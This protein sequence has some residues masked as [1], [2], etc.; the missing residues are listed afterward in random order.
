MNKKL[1]YEDIQKCINDKIAGNGCKLDLTKEEF[2]EEK[3]KQNKTGANVIL[4]ILCK[5]GK[6]FYASYHS[7]SSLNKKQCNKCGIE[8]RARKNE[9]K[10][11]E[12]QNYI[13]GINGNG[14]TLNISEDEFEKY[15]EQQNKSNVNVKIPIMCAC[16]NIFK[17]SF[18]TFVGMNQK[19]CFTC[20]VKIRGKNKETNLEEI[21]SYINGEYGNGCKCYVSL[22]EFE[23]L[24]MEQNKSNV[25]VKIPITC[26]CGDVFEMN[27]SY[28]ISMKQKQCKKC[29]NESRVKKLSISDYDDEINKLKQKDC[30]VLGIN[31]K[32][33]RTLIFIEDKE[34]YK[35]KA[36]VKVIRKF[37]KNG[38]LG[39]DKFN[40]GNPYTVNNIK[41]WLTYNEPKYELLSNTYKDANSKLLWKCS[42]GHKFYAALHKFKDQGRRCP[43]CNASKGEQKVGEWLV[44]NN[45]KIFPQFIFTDLLSDLGNPL[46]FDFGVLDIQNNIHLLIEYDGGQHFEWIPGMMSRENFIK[47]QKHDKMKN[48]Y[49]INHNIN[50]VRIPYW[51]YDNI[52][53]IL[54]EILIKNEYNSPFII[55]NQRYDEIIEFLQDTEK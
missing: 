4:K 24:K 41:V 25:L 7:F 2:E 8:K 52:E 28:F 32:N 40:K 30:I 11:Q 18:H 31:N 36:D 54:N 3:R 22:N 26:A 47:L 53:K 15:K 48:N 49:C 10:F 51:H 44:N 5:C 46:R 1:S 34:G 37:I 19:Q 6:Y 45:Y 43:I 27:Y 38:F 20:G 12:I 39:V 21:K 29:S 9:I 33:H 42:E 35:Y 23:D 14:C 17:I 13:N 16:K 55:N 50:L